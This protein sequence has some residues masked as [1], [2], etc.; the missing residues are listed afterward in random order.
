[1]DYEKLYRQL[2][3]H[4]REIP[5]DG[6]NGVYVEMHHIVPRCLEGCDEKE[7]LICLSGREHY[8]AHK[9]LLKIAE[10][11]FGRHSQEFYKAANAVL[12]MAMDKRGRK[13]S[14]R[15]YEVL[16]IIK[17]EQMRNQV[18]WNKDKKGI[19]SKETIRKMRENH[20]DVSGKNNPM[21]GRRGKLNPNTGRLVSQATRERIGTAHRGKKVS[22]ETRRK[23][24]ESRKGEKNPMFGVNWQKNKTIEE[25]KEWKEKI[26][27][28]KKERSESYINGMAGKHLKEFMSDEEYSLWLSHHHHLSGKDNP[29]YGKVWMCNKDT[30]EIVFVPKE[31]VE[32]KIKQ[33][34]VMGYGRTWWTNGVVEVMAIEAPKGYRKGRLTRKA[35]V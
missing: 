8:V 31:E 2:I 18:P 29:S 4:R 24:S 11:K 16:R 23:I 21:Y 5:I 26:S 19:Y 35:S 12:M 20:A 27:A 3:E 14:S 32:E 9:I 15:D 22:I 17:S 28:T 10:A 1:M 6:K 33:G 30:N 13:V 25:I 7:N 34:F